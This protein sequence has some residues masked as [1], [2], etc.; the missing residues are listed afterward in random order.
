M[1]MTFFE[2][3]SATTTIAMAYEAGNPYFQAL[4]PVVYVSLGLFFGVMIILFIIKFVG[5]VMRWFINVLSGQDG[6]LGSGIHRKDYYKSHWYN[7]QFGKFKEW[8]NNHDELK[9]HKENKKKLQNFL[10]Q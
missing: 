10:K 4:L 9:M 2:F 6:M 5:L 8:K 1:I 3:P 7:P